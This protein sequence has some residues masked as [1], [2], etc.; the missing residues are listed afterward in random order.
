MFL[1]ECPIVVA[2]MRGQCQM[3]APNLEGRFYNI[4]SLLSITSAGPRRA[5]RRGHG[6][7][8]SLTMRYNLARIVFR[9]SWS[10]PGQLATLYTCA[11]ITLVAGSR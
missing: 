3:Q 7:V 9:S 2:V 4:G 10:V 8:P 11:K 1:C 6:L 5:A